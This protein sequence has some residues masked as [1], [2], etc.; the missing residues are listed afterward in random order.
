MTF[1]KVK[2]WLN[3]LELIGN[4]SVWLA[5]Q[6]KCLLPIE[7]WLLNDNLLQ[8]FIGLA[9]LVIYISTILSGIQRYLFV[10]LYPLGYRFGGEWQRPK[11]TVAYIK[12]GVY[13]SFIYKSK[14][15]KTEFH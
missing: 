4:L 8:L 7:F 3:Q 2:L 15:V 6:I 12:I 9:A 14:M 5:L 11:I 1:V 10:C 13:F